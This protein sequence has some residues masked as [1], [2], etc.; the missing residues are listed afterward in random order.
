LRYMDFCNYILSIDA[1]YEAKKKE[2][3][4]G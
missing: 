3:Q 2:A 1:Y 4:V